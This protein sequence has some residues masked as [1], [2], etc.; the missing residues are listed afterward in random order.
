MADTMVHYSDDSLMKFLTKE[1]MKT[2]APYLF[3]TEPT[4]PNLTN[5]YE[6]ANTETIIDDMAKLGWGVVDCKQQRNNPKK[7]SC[8]SF[9]MVVFQNPD[10]Y[11][12]REDENGNK[13]IDCFPRIIVQNSHDGFK[14]FRF[15]C[16]L[17]RLVCSN[18]LIVA[19]EEFE[20][21]SI[22]HINYTFDELRRIVAE[23]IDKIEGTIKVM[24]KMENTILTNEQKAE[25]ATEALRIRKNNNELV[26]DNDTIDDILTPTRKEDEVDNLWTIFNVI[27]EKMMKGDFSLTN[28][29]NP[30]KSRK[31]RPITGAAKDLEFNQKFFQFAHNYCDRI[32]A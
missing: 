8:K 7:P 15:M 28:T 19:D 11:I 32:A 31:A 16:G 22:R 14:S 26:V 4:N 29:K 1:E 10:I 6:F 24:D 12:E 21:V 17:F 2:K 18:G 5:R 13:T 27:Q 9:H 23:S 25:L 30:K 3:C 20:N